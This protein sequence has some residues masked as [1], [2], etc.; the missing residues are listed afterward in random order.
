MKCLA[1]GCPLDAVDGRRVCAAHAD[2][3]DRVLADNRF[4]RETPP[5]MYA[6][7]ITR[8]GELVR[9]PDGG[10]GLDGGIQGAIGL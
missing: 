7:T 5:S 6:V 9:R 2:Y 4:M 1:V 10:F 8:G 3:F